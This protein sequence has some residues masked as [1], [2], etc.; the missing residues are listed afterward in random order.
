MLLAAWSLHLRTLRLSP[1][2][3]PPAPSPLGIDDPCC[4]L[5]AGDTEDPLPALRGGG[6]CWGEMQEPGRH[7]PTSTPI[8]SVSSA[9]SILDPL[10]PL[11]R[12]Q[13][14]Q[15]WCLPLAPGVL[16]GVPDTP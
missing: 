10:V 5:D 6:V 14:W 1:L 2:E 4:V 7:P 16:L 15:W 9:T 13:L 3:R 8:P 11:P 12:T